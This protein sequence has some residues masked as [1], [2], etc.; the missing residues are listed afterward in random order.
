MANNVA[1]NNVTRCPK[2]DT[3]FRVTDAHLNSAKGAVRCGSCLNIFN[4]RE[5][6][7]EDE[8]TQKDEDDILISDDMDEE[9][10]LYASSDMEGNVIMASTFGPSESN[11]FEREF[12]EDEDDDETDTDESWAESLLADDDDEPAAL[13]I[14][15]EAPEE[16]EEVEAPKRQLFESR[17]ASSGERGQFYGEEPPAPPGAKL[18]PDHFS[19]IEDLRKSE[20]DDPI[21]HKQSSK[22][23]E[24]DT[25]L[26]ENLDD[27]AYFEAPDYH[28]DDA[29]DEDY[30][31]TDYEN[32]EAEPDIG[33]ID[34]IDDY[35]YQDQYG[36]TSN[37]RYIHAIEPEPVEFNVS[38]R[39][40]IW[41]SKALW[42]GLAATAGILLF[43][44]LAIFRFDDLSTIQPWRSYY[45]EVCSF[46]SCELPQLRDRSK[47]KAS[48]LVVRTHPAIEDA[49]MVDAIINNTARF[50]QSF[51]PLDL[52]FVDIKNNPVAA[53]RF[54]AAEYLGGELAGRDAMP[55][56]QPVH[57]AI[58]INDPGPDAVSYFITIPE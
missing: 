24:D 30:I 55:V 15:R 39:Y 31:Q 17:D 43:V 52:V 21:T 25:D 13:K 38:T 54:E 34:E 58:E 44:Q 48:N 1:N 27:D 53:R 2:C 23:L 36:A 51:P 3:S 35:A 41:Q 4:A 47:I 8:K 56:N 45:G 57:I 49:L 7:V 46:L 50:P 33:D 29:D 40:P 14:K 18:S 16:P 28:E 26:D 22:Q 19:L 37:S 5:H 12:N 10:D 42:T 9:E 11:L 20:D 6:L 32:F